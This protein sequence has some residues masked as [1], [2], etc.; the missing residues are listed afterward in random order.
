ME[1]GYYIPEDGVYDTPALCI[2]NNYCPGGGVVGTPSDGETGLVAC[3]ETFALYAAVDPATAA[4]QHNDD[5]DCVFGYVPYGGDTLVPCEN[6]INGVYYSGVDNTASDDRGNSIT[7]CGN[8]IFGSDNVIEGQ[9]VYVRGR[10]NSVTGN[11]VHGIYDFSGDFVKSV[12]IYEAA[13]GYAYSIYIAANDNTVAGCTLSAGSI[14][15]STNSHTITDA[16]DTEANA[17]GSIIIMAGTFTTEENAEVI[18]TDGDISEQHRPCYNL[19][20]GKLTAATDADGNTIVGCNNTVSGNLKEKGGADLATAR[21]FGSNN[22]IVDNIASGIVT[23]DSYQGPNG[24]GIVVGFSS[25]GPYSYGSNGNEVVSNDADYIALF[26]STG[27]LIESNTAATDEIQTNYLY[28][29]K[30]SNNVAHSGMSNRGEIDLYTDTS[31]NVED[32][33]ADYIGIS[34]SVKTVVKGNRV[35]HKDGVSGQLELYSDVSDDI[36]DNQAVRAQC[37]RIAQRVCTAADS[38]LA[39]RP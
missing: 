15:I 19:V 28:N 9:Q 25:D 33:S 39:P 29:S 37:A 7:G 11:D 34:T 36:E 16:T 17:D 23:A 21:V 26:A 8:T 32:N 6:L 22:V 35:T 1:P 31:V 13:P 2:A 3:P 4:T 20:N 18:N 24:H 38:P 14:L 27:N 30:V 5:S 10:G 12:G